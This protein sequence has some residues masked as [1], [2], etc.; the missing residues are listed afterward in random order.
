MYF[1]GAGSIVLRDLMPVWKEAVGGIP[2]FIWLPKP[3][4]LAQGA[5]VEP[6]LRL[7]GVPAFISREV[8]ASSFVSFRYSSEKAKRELGWK[9]EIGFEDGLRATVAWYRANSDWVRRTRSGEYREYY[10]RVYG[11]S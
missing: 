10:E 6:I 5:L 3:L 7:L 1:F 8:V 4:A 2:P 9:P 11:R